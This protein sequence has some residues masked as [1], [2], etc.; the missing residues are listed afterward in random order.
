MIKRPSGL[1]R[2]ILHL[3]RQFIR[4]AYQKPQENRAHF[5]KHFRYEFQRYKDLPRKDFST[6]E[7]LLRVG[8][9]RLELFSSPEVKDIH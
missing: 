4:L 9:R 3:Y 7:H 1:Q 5:E 2:Q 8:R 6:I